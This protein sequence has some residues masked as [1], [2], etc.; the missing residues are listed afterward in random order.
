[1]DFAFL[2]ADAK[3][4]CLKLLQKDPSMRIGSGE[5]DAEEIKAH[6]WFS[7]I[8]WDDIKNKTLTPP[9]CPQL[10]KASDTKHF[11]PEFTNL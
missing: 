8:K 6:P 9:Y 11:P 5:T 2:G 1:M 3:D 10:D 7:C 4:L